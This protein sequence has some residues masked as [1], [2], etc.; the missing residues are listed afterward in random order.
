MSQVIADSREYRAEVV[1][2]IKEAGCQV[3]QKQLEVGDYIAGDLI[4]ERKSA[5]DFI[6]S[7]ADGRLFEQISKLTSSGLRPVIVIEGDLWRAVNMREVH[8]NAVLGAQIAILR[9]G[10][11]VLYTRSPEQT[12][13]AI[14]YSA[15]QTNRSGGIK[16]PHPKGRDIRRLQ[17]EFLSSLPGVGVKTAEQLIRRYGSPLKALQNYRSWPLSE[18]ALIKIKRVLEGEQED[19]GDLSAFF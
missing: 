6:S 10:V 12:G 8:P 9:M 2:F 19:R 16:I 7:I 15:K 4:F 13:Y 14:C 11:S 3:V 18:R 1:R 5:H 17:I